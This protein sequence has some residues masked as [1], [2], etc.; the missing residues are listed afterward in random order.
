MAV[1]KYII[2]YEV[3]DY[4]RPG[5]AERVTRRA[6]VELSDKTMNAWRKGWATGH[7][8]VMT[9]A[10]AYEDMTAKGRVEKILSVTEA[11]MVTA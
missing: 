2:E 4:H 8:H 11:P 6:V 3:T 7:Y 1:K 5:G 10:Q 9:A